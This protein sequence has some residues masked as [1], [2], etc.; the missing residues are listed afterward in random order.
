MYLR[1]ITV[2]KIAKG[3]RTLQD[4]CICFSYIMYL[5]LWQL[6]VTLY[7]VDIF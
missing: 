4:I 5:G 2:Q 1:G 7:F 3:L 6:T